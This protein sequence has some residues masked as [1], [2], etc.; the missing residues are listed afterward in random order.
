MFEYTY[1]TYCYS[2][3]SVDKSIIK[4]HI[5]SYA[6]LGLGQK[7][8]GAT[9]WIHNT[10]PIHELTWRITIHHSSRNLALTLL[11]D[12]PDDSPELDIQ[13]FSSAEWIWLRDGKP[14][15]FAQ[16]YDHGM[17]PKTSG[18]KDV[19]YCS[20]CGTAVKMGVVLKI[21]PVPN[22]SL[23]LMKNH[24]EL[25][26]RHICYLN[27]VFFRWSQSRGWLCIPSQDTFGQEPCRNPGSNMGCLL[28]DSRVASKYLATPPFCADYAIIFVGYMPKSKRLD[29]DLKHQIMF[30]PS[31]CSWPNQPSLKKKTNLS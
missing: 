27:V 14:F 31:C 17:F 2:L 28:H 23:P 25:F 3:V 21:L 26:K 13:G 20:P 9:R 15:I 5:F 22:S 6:G 24:I 18:T 7:K 10:L 8:R 1:D 11:D 16:Q 19:P 4:K 29:A 12:S 30:N